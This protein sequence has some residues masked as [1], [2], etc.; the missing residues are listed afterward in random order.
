MEPKST[1][2]VGLHPVPASYGMT[3][4]EYA[5]MANGE[6]WLKNG[7]KCNLTVIKLK[8]YTHNSKYKLPINPSPN[9][10]SME[11]IYLYPSL[12]L[13]EGTVVSVGRGTDHPFTVLGH[14]LLTQYSFSFVPEPRKGISDN[15]PLKGKTCYGLDLRNEVPALI[16][17]GHIELKW[18]IEMYSA[19]KDKVQFFT[20]YFDKLA[21]SPKLREQIIAGESAEKIRESWQPGLNKFKEIRKKYLLYK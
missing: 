5:Q 8:N 18:L 12:C 4:G 9:L 6:G 14:P 20:P 19:L 1:S 17:N 2:F 3:I 10:S 11:A 13:F 16:K 7:V 15:P 21:G